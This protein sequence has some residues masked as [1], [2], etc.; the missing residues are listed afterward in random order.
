LQEAQGF[1]R[2]DSKSRLVY[3][4]SN[5]SLQDEGKGLETCNM[6]AAAS[7]VKDENKLITIQENVSDTSDSVKLSPDQVGNKHFSPRLF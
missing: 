7:S 3:D 4:Y 1:S 5:R 6:T 2:T